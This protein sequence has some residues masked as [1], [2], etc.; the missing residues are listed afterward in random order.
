MIL[1]YSFVKLN[2]KHEETFLS[3]KLPKFFKDSTEHLKFPD[4]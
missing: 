1:D 2:E 4:C 3:S